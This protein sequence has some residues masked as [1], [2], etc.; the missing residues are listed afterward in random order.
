MIHYE[1]YPSESTSDIYNNAIKEIWPSLNRY[2]KIVCPVYAG[3]VQGHNIAHMPTLDL[4]KE[5]KKFMDQGKTKFI[6]MCESEDIRTDSTLE[7]IHNMLELLPELDHNNVFCVF[8]S[9]NLDKVYDNYFQSSKHKKKINVLGVRYFEQVANNWLKYQL[10]LQKL[11]KYEVSTLLKEKVFLCFN[12]VQRE[13]RVML[14]DRIFEQE[15][16]E[17]SFYSFQG[18]QGFVGGNPGNNKS[19]WINYIDHRYNHFLKNKNL[20]PIK[21]NITEQRSNP[22]TLLPEDYDYFTNSYFS[23]VTE[24]E[25]FENH[26]TQSSV[27]FS[28]KI[29]KPIIMLHP[30]IL[31]GRYKML[32]RLQEFGYKTFHPYIDESYDSIRNPELRMDAIVNEIKRLSNQTHAQWIEW[33]KAIAPIVEHNKDFLRKNKK[34]FEVEITSLF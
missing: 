4:A 13:H 10:E 6:F 24:T 29:W 15:L 33:Q 16:F 12:K 23:V 21:L 27:F 2:D 31:A 34:F 20:F 1:P 22:V 30:F 19:N 25:Y 26:E 8:G 32:S 5:I 17:K 11:I 7:A 18:D 28:E 3:A 9:T 14:L